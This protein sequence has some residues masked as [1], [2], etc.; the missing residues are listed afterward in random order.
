MPNVLRC[1][2][3]TEESRTK[4]IGSG[5]T[6]VNLRGHQ[7]KI[8]AGAA[9]AGTE[10]TLS[11]PASERVEVHIR[12]NGQEQFR[13][14]AP[15]ELTISYARCRDED[16]PRGDL[17]IYRLTPDLAD[18][19]QDLGGRDDRRGK[20]VTTDLDHLSGYLVGGG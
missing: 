12:A 3:A 7:L 2:S 5:T 10:I 15:V 9:P 19:E 20:K 16:L 8:P 17:H 1:G 4:T 18:I 14:G 6:I 11:V 13:F